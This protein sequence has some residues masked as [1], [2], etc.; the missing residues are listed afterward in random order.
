MPSLEIVGVKELPFSYFIS[1]NQFDIWIIFGIFEKGLPCLVHR[2]SAAQIH[3]K[4]AWGHPAW[5]GPKPLGKVPSSRARPNPVRNWSRSPHGDRTGTVLTSNRRPLTERHP[6]MHPPMVFAPSVY[7]VPPPSS[8]QTSPLPSPH[9]I[10]LCSHRVPLPLRHRWEPPVSTTF[11]SPSLPRPRAIAVWPELASQHRLRALASRSLGAASSVR[12][13]HRPISESL[14]STLS[15]KLASVELLHAPRGQTAAAVLPRL[16]ACAPR[17]HVLPL[18]AR[19]LIKWWRGMS[20]L[21]TPSLVSTCSAGR[22][23]AQ[24]WCRWLPSFAWATAVLAP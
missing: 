1:W 17:P 6:H 15:A 23:T 2:N 13:V 7:P 19:R 24:G 5:P 21:V 4:R 8:K 10:L 12:A 20:F 11:P 22:T 16:T 3:L 18:L 9:R 14:I